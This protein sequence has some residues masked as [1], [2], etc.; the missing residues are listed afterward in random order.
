MVT[1]TRPTKG[2]LWGKSFTN[3]KVAFRILTTL[4]SH[5][6]LRFMHRWQSH[7]HMTVGADFPLVTNE[8]CVPELLSQS[9]IRS[10][11]MGITILLY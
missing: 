11:A 1:Q 4:P 2:L 8:L 7:I 9:L 10:F 3:T 5:Y 6:C